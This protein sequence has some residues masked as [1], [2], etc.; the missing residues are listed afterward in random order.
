MLRLLCSASPPSDA[1]T[2]ARS[3]WSPQSLSGNWCW[4][5]DPE[6]CCPG[7]A[8]QR[9]ITTFYSPVACDNEAGLPVPNDNILAE[10]SRIL[11]T[12]SLQAKVVQA[13]IIVAET[14]A[15]GAFNVGSVGNNS[16]NALAKARIRIMDKELQPIY[17]RPRA[18]DIRDSLADISK[19]KGYW[20]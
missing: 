1:R 13:S 10:V 8:H 4:P 19:T 12:E 20:L 15:T 14:N 11:S 9:S 2:A 6:Y 18:A 7:Y 5:A 3:N 17:Q 16:L